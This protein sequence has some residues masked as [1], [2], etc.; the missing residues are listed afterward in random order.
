MKKK[1]IIALSIITLIISLIVLISAADFTPSGNINLRS[2]YN[3]TGLNGL[4][5]F[6]LLG[7]IDANQKN[8]TNVNVLN[9]TKIYGNGSGITGIVTDTSNSTT[10]W[11]GVSSFVS[12]WF[13]NSANTLTFNET[14][15]NRSID[16]RTVSKLNTTDQRYNES[17]VIS[18]NNA[19]WLSTYNITYDAKVTDNSSWNESRANTLYYNRSSNLDTGNYN[20]TASNFIGDGS[21]LNFTGIYVSVSQNGDGDFDATGCNTGNSCA[22]PIINALNYVNNLGGG[23]VILK[24]GL[25]Q[26]NK[27]I[28]WT[29][30]NVTLIGEGMDATT[31]MGK[32]NNVF[33]IYNNGVVVNIQNLKIANTAN[34]QDIGIGI[35]FRNNNASLRA[36]ITS[37]LMLDK[38][39]F[40]GLTLNAIY[41]ANDY[42]DGPTLGNIIIKNSKFLNVCYNTDGTEYPGFYHIVAIEGNKIANKTLLV[43]NNEW[44]KGNSRDNAIQ[45]DINGDS[46][47]GLG[48][49]GS[50]IDGGIIRNN[51]IYGATSECAVIT[52]IRN[53][54]FDGNYFEDCDRIGFDFHRCYRTIVVNNVVNRSTYRA[55]RIDQCTESIWSNNQAFNVGLNDTHF[56]GI[57]GM[58]ILDSSNNTI[59]QNYILAD[60][61]DA[62]EINGDSHGNYVLFNHVL[63]P[64]KNIYVNYS[65]AT[66]NVIIQ[67]DQN[68]FDYG[69]QMDL[70]NNINLSNNNISNIDSLISSKLNITG[71]SNFYGNA[72]FNNANITAEGINII[73]DA[74]AAGK[75]TVVGQRPYPNIYL[76]SN[77]DVSGNGP[78]ILINNTYDSIEPNNVTHEIN[79]WSSDSSNGGVGYAS[80]ILVIAENFGTQYGLGF[81][82]GSFSSSERLR[83]A[84]NGDI[85]IT[86][87]NLSSQGIKPNQDSSHELGSSLFRWLKAWNVNLDVSNNANISSLNVYS[88]ASITNLTISGSSNVYTKTESDNNLS[89]RLLA[90]DQRYNETSRIDTINSTITDSNASWTSTYNS[91]YDFQSGR[92]TSINQTINGNLNWSNINSST[93]PISCPSGT[94]I[95]K[96]GSSNTCT[97]VN[98]NISVENISASKISISTPN[99]I[100]GYFEVSGQQAFPNLYLKSDGSSENLGPEILINN[101]HGSI[102]TNNISHEINFWSSDVS[103]GGTGY[104]ARILVIPEN[105]GTQYGISFFT[106]SFTLLE[107]LR[108][109]SNGDINITT[110]NLLIQTN[111]KSCY[112][113]DACNV[114]T[115]YNGSTLITK[116]N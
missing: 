66:N 14:Q 74:D 71:I 103:A 46:S 40:N 100:P 9:A 44:F 101:T 77:G 90:T 53:M 109:L 75:F 6:K 43:E 2:L 57:G 24:R 48:M 45:L 32:S 106:G 99:G 7:N 85:N 107:R 26:T 54:L 42:I 20:I 27:A 92:I 93:L 13:Y 116:V 80:R 25:Y 79:F 98:G 73:S 16:D 62:I 36:D 34:G 88:N 63:G 82:T 12:K 50:A 96:I 76:S 81:F 17:G 19:S 52:D 38:V 51:R 58:S 87:G 47:S 114:Y 39:F 78:E 41:Y 72:N 22:T 113:G 33:E 60:K 31:I 56:L 95:T 37:D 49:N 68:Y 23:V 112:D 21:K 64:Y 8:I 55:Y 97:A 102:E 59:T 61:N 4:G 11:S 1:T 35:F 84:Y 5:P 111:K 83:I 91:T 104:A 86:T 67:P 69:N 115:Y 110:G 3:I 30:T 15:L 105:L 28:N 65:S 94:Y 18:S 89:L 29:Y 10:F 108:I 70:R